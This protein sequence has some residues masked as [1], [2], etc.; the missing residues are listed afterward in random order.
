[1]KKTEVY[2]FEGD[3]RENQGLSAAP[4]HRGRMLTTKVVRMMVITGRGTTVHSDRATNSDAPAK[5]TLLISSACTMLHFAWR[6][7]MPTPSPT[8][9]TLTATGMAR[10]A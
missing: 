8:I 5:T 6:G 2:T 9:M 7:T 3:N 4:I 10:R 1:M